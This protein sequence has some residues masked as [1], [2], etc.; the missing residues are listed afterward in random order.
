MLL[1]FFLTI[2]L[3][4]NLSAQTYSISNGQWDN[5]SS[6][7]AYPINT[8]SGYIIINDDSIIATSKIIG[9]QCIFELRDN[10]I[11]VIDYLEFKNESKV[12]IEKGS[13]IIAKK[14]VN[15]NNSINIVVD[16]FIQADEFENKTG[17]IVSGDGIIESDL[18]TGNG[19]TFDVINESIIEV[20]TGSSGLPIE[21][22]KIYIEDCKLKWS[23]FSELNCNYFKIEGS[24]DAIN[25]KEVYR[26]AGSGNS[27][28]IKN[29][30]ASCNFDFNY[31]RLIEVDYDN[32]ITIF[33]TLNNTCINKNLNVYP[34][35]TTDKIRIIG[36]NEDVENL[37]IINTRG[38]QVEYII[39]NKDSISIYNLN[40]GIY[41]LNIDNTS[42]KIIKQ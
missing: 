37:I 42:I 4:L 3:H 38:D 21:I 40:S 36:L 1:L 20:I 6:W 24:N 17:G 5:S 14:I 11:L 9:S 39:L 23:T 15:K 32:S 12:F 7:S 19:T 8:N 28:T 13:K 34:N 22:N 26:I 41:I 18:F 29:Y 2:L 33:K 16:G 25:F 35:P 31:L 30:E 10:G 27:N